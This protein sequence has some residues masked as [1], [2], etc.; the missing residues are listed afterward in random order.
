MTVYMCEGSFE[1]ILCG[2]YD[3]WMSKKGHEH[4]RLELEG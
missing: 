2:V 3:A 4:V 1:G